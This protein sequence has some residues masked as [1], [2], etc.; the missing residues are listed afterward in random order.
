M[1][2]AVTKAVG[3]IE[4]AVAVFEKAAAEVDE[5]VAA[6]DAH[7]KAVNERITALCDERDDALTEAA[8]AASLAER[9]RGFT[10]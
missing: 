10:Q 3:R 6:L 8:R 9:L 1:K 7:A 5:A 2:N 4:S